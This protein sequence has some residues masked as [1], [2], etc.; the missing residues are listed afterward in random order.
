MMRRS[1]RIIMMSTIYLS[2]FVMKEEQRFRDAHVPRG[3]GSF[4]VLPDKSIAHRLNALRKYLTHLLLDGFGNDKSMNNCDARLP[5]CNECVPWPVPQ[6]QN[7]DKESM[8]TMCCSSTMLMLITRT[9]IESLLADSY[10]SISSVYASLW[11]CKVNHYEVCKS[12]VC[13]SRDVQSHT[14]LL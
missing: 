14:R 1:S 5:L 4:L 8:S 9:S 3:F 6:C 12:F 10:Y 13:L 7:R 2:T 11:H